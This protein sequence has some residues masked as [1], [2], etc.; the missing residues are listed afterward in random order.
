MGLAIALSVGASKASY[1]RLLAATTCHVGA[2]M[3]VVSGQ[4][5]LLVADGTSARTTIFGILVASEFVDPVR[6][7]LRARLGIAFESGRHCLILG[8]TFL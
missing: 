1:V 6:A 7:R 8:F 5:D 2:Q 3:S 4:A